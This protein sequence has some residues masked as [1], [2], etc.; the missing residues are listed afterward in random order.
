MSRIWSRVDI[1]Q[2]CEGLWGC[3]EENSGG[4]GEGFYVEE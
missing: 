2:A 1:I 4:A 3:S